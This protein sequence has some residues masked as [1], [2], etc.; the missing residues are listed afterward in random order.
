MEAPKHLL[1][2]SDISFVNADIVAEK[3]TKCFITDKIFNDDGIEYRVATFYPQ[4][5]SWYVPTE[6]I[7]NII[8][9]IRLNDI[10]VKV[11]L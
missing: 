11:T 8:D 3:N 7:A 5:V 1:K 4:E 10:N 9:Y 2:M 6:N